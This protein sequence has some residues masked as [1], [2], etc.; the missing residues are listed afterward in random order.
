MAQLTDALT[1]KDSELKTKEKVLE[2][3]QS[4]YQ[5]LEKEY[6]KVRDCIPKLEVC[7]Y[8]FMYVCM[9]DIWYI[10]IIEYRGTILFSQCF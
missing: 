6:C 1:K 8:N 3:V 10:L 7:L 5:A 4:S 2:Q 9:Y